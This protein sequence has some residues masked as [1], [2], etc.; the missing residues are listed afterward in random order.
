MNFFFALPKDWWGTEPEGWMPQGKGPC[1]SSSFFFEQVRKVNK[2]YKHACPTGWRKHIPS[3]SLSFTSYTTH[4][5]PIPHTSLH[6]PFCKPSRVHQLYG[7][8]LDHCSP[9]IRLMSDLQSS[10]DT[11][12][13]P[14]WTARMQAAKP[15]ACLPWRFPEVLER[16]TRYLF[17]AYTRQDSRRQKLHLY[18][19]R[20]RSCAGKRTA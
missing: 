13:N 20:I 6:C 14:A 9:A 12:R 11:I 19:E 17:S 4:H 5:R 1:L 7:D 8:H 3:L 15:S 18:A 10:G 16:R 2:F